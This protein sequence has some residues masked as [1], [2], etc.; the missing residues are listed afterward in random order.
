VSEKVREALINGRAGIIKL[1]QGYEI[2]PA[3]I[4]RKIQDRDAGSVIVLNQATQ[5]VAAEDDP[6]AA[7]EIPDDLMW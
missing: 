2:V 3:E 7:F 4:A 5:D 1:E 6:Y